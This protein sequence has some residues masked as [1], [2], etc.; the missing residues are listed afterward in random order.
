M[1]DCLTHSPK[2]Y[3]M[4][5]SSCTN[6][7]TECLQHFHIHIESFNVF[8]ATKKNKWG[9]WSCVLEHPHHFHSLA[10]RSASI[11]SSY[12]TY[13]ALVE[14]KNTDGSTFFPWKHKEKSQWLFIDSA[15]NAALP[16]LHEM[17]EKFFLFSCSWI[18][19]KDFFC[20]MCGIEKLLTGAGWNFMCGYFDEDCRG[21]MWIL[22]WY[23]RLLWFSRVL[24]GCLEGLDLQD[25]FLSTACHGWPHART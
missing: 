20:L 5:I 17:R 8:R 2:K 4:C 9:K 1:G 16:G 7:V 23:L 14:R 12:Y 25:S 3:F 13:T 15:F 6:T 19:K 22:I 10:F 18:R 11:L 24:W 21:W